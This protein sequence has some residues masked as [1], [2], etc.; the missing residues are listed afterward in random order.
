MKNCFDQ[1]VVQMF[2]IF[3]GFD[4]WLKNLKFFQIL[5]RTENTCECEYVRLDY[6]ARLFI[7]GICDI[8][9]DSQGSACLFFVTRHDNR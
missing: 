5:A 1:E 6:Y 9:L 4:R 2:A 8:K 7:R 3:E